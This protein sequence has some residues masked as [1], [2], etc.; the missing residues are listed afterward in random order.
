MF[1]VK[2]P[3]NPQKDRDWAENKTDIYL[4]TAL[5]NPANVIVSGV[6]TAQELTELQVVSQKQTLVYDHHVYEN[7]G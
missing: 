3:T 5:K 2:H 6:M 7:P 4:R 1:R